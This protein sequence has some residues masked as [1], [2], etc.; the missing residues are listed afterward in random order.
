MEA[1]ALE[2]L[3]ENTCPAW[4]PVMIAEIMASTATP[5][6]PGPDQLANLI[7]GSAAFTEIWD[8]GQPRPHVAKVSVA[9]PKFAPIAPFR[10]IGVPELA[11]TEALATWLS[12]SVPLIEW[13]AKPQTHRLRPGS[14]RHYS[15][16]WIP[17]RARPPRLIEAPKPILKGIQRQILHDILDRVPPH[18]SAH[19][20][21]KGRSC[22]SAAQL[23]AGE[24]V[25]VCA[26]LKDF[27]LRISLGRVHGLFRSLGYPWRIARLLTDLCG[28]ATP[29]DIL[30][31]DGTR[32]MMDDETRRLLAQRHLPQG[33]PTSPALANLCIRQLDRRLSGLAHSL[34]ARYTR[35]GDDLAFSG[36]PDFAGRVERFLPLVQ[37]ICADAG[38]P[39]NPRKT[40]VMGQ[41]GCQRLLGLVVNRHVNVPR[42]KYDRLKAILHNSLRHG[43]GAENRAGHPDFR[44]HLAG[45][46][47]WVESISRR[48]GHRLHLMF[49]RID[50]SR[51]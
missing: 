31:G 11:T 5:Y 28:T 33:A 2:A 35:Y 8:L 26:D 38:L 43:P 10:D 15:Y 20:Y 17:K 42:A 36:D 1:V 49:D 29:G 27:F 6:P 46:I 21:R 3:G 23:H 41:G 45:Q 40:R 13:L 32:T 51:T 30:A 4:L 7:R 48:K 18:E 12:L 44:A 37:T 19:G 50:W 39:L 22:V 34:S 47:A 24:A 25:V 9:P 14:A 16:A